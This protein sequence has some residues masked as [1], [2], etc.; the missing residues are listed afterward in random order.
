[1][2]IP[3]RGIFLFYI[4]YIDTHYKNQHTP[5][6]CLMILS[7]FAQQHPS[8]APPSLEMRDRGLSLLGNVT[9]NPGVSQ[10][11]PYPYPWKPVPA[12]MGTGF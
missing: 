5:A 7:G 3:K 4:L 9:G 2:P 1:M 12:T 6:L 8:L 10:G 11:N